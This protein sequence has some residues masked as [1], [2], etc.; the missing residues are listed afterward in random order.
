MVQLEDGVHLGLGVADTWLEEIGQPLQDYQSLLVADRNFEQA[1][2][3]DKVV[4]H[5]PLRTARLGRDGQPGDTVAAEQRVFRFDCAGTG[6]F[7]ES[8]I[9]GVHYFT[10]SQ[11][12]VNASVTSIWHHRQLVRPSSDATIGR[13]EKLWACGRPR[14]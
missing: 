5:F 3:V 7:A 12:V 13:K 11:P 2:S 4:E 1:L 6:D 9:R 14:S 8:G 10:L